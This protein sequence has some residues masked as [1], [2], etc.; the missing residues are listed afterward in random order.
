MTAV[1]RKAG[2]FI[3]DGAVL[4]QEFGLSQ[5]EV[6]TRMRDGTIS[7]RCE[8][9]TDED[10]GRWRLTFYHDGRACRLVVDE[11]GTVLTRVTFPVRATP[12]AND[13]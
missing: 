12:S 3:V 11:V 2:E 5:E 7:S 8:T 10:S 4:A 1:D 13:T 9:G 6:R